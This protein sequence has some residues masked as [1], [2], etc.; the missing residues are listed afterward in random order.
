MCKS[1]L[2]IRLAG[3]RQVS[4]T[5]ATPGMTRKLTWFRLERGVGIAQLSPRL[6]DTDSGI[7]TQITA[8]DLDG[9]ARIDIAIAN[10][11][12]AFVFLQR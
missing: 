4:L 3:R 7:G 2:L 12:G 9:D 6:I 8:A 10:K 5:S 11:K 1:R